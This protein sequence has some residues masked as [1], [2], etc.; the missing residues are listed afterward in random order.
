MA[1]H[2]SAISVLNFILRN[3]FSRKSRDFISKM[4]FILHHN[5]IMKGVRRLKSHFR[6]ITSMYIPT[7]IVEL[8][9]G[10]LS[11]SVL[12]L[13]WSEEPTR[14][15]TTLK[16]YLDDFS[17][18]PVLSSSNF[19]NSLDFSNFIRIMPEKNASKF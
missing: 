13:F 10:I 8:E 17:L 19:C 18:K 2:K 1:S 9:N 11:A 3:I 5:K 6:L 12:S 7:F 15:F 4:H 16:S 14:V